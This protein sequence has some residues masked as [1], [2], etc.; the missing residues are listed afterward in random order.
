MGALFFLVLL[1]VIEFGRALFVWNLLDEATRRGARFAA[2]CPVTNA[3]DIQNI[4]DMARFDGQFINGLE[5]ANISLQYLKDDGSVI[6]DPTL[7]DEVDGFGA[8]RYVRVSVTG[9]THQ[10]L[11]P[12][13]DINLL[14]PDFS[15]TVPSE[16]LGVHPAAAGPAV[17][18]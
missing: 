9:Y 1:A 11:I 15:T 8:I 12:F 7:D 10:M 16:S 6:A 17:C 3:V 2:V 4:Q 18:S 14:A 13:I 5:Q